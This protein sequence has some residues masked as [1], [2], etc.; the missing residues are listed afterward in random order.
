MGTT[1]ALGWMEGVVDDA[2]LLSIS[3][4]SFW[5]GR[6]ERE[7]GLSRSASYDFGMVQKC[8]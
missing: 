8:R 6:K 2:M 7:L 4:L 5:L 3:L 1:S